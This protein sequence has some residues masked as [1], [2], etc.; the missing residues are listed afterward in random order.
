M[1]SSSEHEVRSSVPT[2]GQLSVVEVTLTVSRSLCLCLV[3]AVSNKP[4][5]K[6]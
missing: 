5:V 6:R 2:A 4:P 3:S 1:I